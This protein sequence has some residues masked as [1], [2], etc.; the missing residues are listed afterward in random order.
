MHNTCIGSQKIFSYAIC[1]R[2]VEAKGMSTDCTLALG[3]DTASAT[4]IDMLE[5]KT[6]APLETQDNQVQ[7]YFR[8][9]EVKTVRVK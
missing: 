2:L 1:V 6:L 4:E 8:A 9:F 7:L 5:T 3:F